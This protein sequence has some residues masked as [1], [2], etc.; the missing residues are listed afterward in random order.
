[1]LVSETSNPRNVAT[2]KMPT[3]INKTDIKV[4]PESLSSP[5]DRW[6]SSHLLARCNTASHQHRHD[7]AGHSQIRRYQRNNQR[8]Q[9]K[10]AE[11]WV[12]VEPQ[13]MTTS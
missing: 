13:E 2:G 3:R 5:Q 9:S 7:Q 4:G 12:K 6:A 10:V 1:M 8:T 11:D